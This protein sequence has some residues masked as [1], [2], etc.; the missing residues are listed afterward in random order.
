MIDVHARLYSDAPNGI[1]GHSFA[2]HRLMSVN[3]LLAELFRDGITVSPYEGVAILQ[4]LLAEAIAQ[5][6]V[7]RKDPDVS[8]GDER[9]ISPRIDDIELT[10]EGLV[11]RR[12]SSTSPTVAE[13]AV[14]LAAVL[15]ERWGV[16]PDD[17]R[18]VI[19][20]GLQDRSSD[21]DGFSASLRVF[22]RGAPPQVV[23][24]LLATRARLRSSPAVPAAPVEQVL[25]HAEELAQATRNERTSP[26]PDVNT[27]AVNRHL[28]PRLGWR[29]AAAVALIAVPTAIGSFLLAQREAA[30]KNAGDP[31]TIVASPKLAPPI[32]PP[33]GAA[34]ALAHS[35][36]PT[37]REGNATEAQGRL[38]SEAASANPAGEA[39]GAAS[40]TSRQPELGA[41]SPEPLPGFSPAFAAQGSVIYFHTGGSSAQESD[42][43]MA[44]EARR[45]IPIVR[46]GA[47]N[48][49]VQPSPDGRVLAFDSDRDGKRGI[50]VANR[51]GS[52]VK[53]VSGPGWAAVPTWAP[54]GSRLAFVRAETGR[55]NVWNLWLLSLDSG[56][57][58]R[59]TSYRY[60][61]T[62]GASWFPGGERIV[63][64]H[65]TTLVV[66]DLVTGATREFKSPIPKR[67][68]RTAAVSPDGRR[69]IFQVHRDG[70]W[71]LGLG[72]G[73]MRRVLADPSAEEFSWAPDGTRVAFHSRRGGRWGVQVAWFPG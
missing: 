9:H 43:A 71:L 73:S 63:Y 34:P 68:V 65:E 13:M 66:R 24:D 52:N 12:S 4:Q 30:R 49:H 6:R 50:Y 25:V 46:D 47:R 21:L 10:S 8:V 2:L 17:L 5:Q 7:E 11:R 58:Q 1:D 27:A 41:V 64:T 44:D 32:S 15:D 70:A 57:T 38:P 20:H 51:D 72:D 48:Y 33:N 59:L 69:V 45:I 35:V 23:R 40:D 19:A 31:E 60:G 28:H 22:E 56:E 39:A 53:R 36:A 16:V 42:L 61:Q 62:W 14:L 26:R 18:T 55:P 29:A 54:D 67:L 37:V 3:V